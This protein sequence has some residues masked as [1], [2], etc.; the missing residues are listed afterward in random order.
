MSKHKKRP[1]AQRRWIQHPFRGKAARTADG[2]AVHEPDGR[3]ARLGLAVLRGLTDRVVLPIARNPR[4]ER[5]T[6]RLAHLRDGVR[7]KLEHVAA[8]VRRSG[9]TAEH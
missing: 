6:D 7:D 8:L 9:P 2:E 1:W 3:V 5:A 4:V